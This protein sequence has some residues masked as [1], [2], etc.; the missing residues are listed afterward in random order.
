M[1]EDD[2]EVD[3]KMDIDSNHNSGNNN[4]MMVGDVM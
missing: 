1:V 3:M 2:D 4:A